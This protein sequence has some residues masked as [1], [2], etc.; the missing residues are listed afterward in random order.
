MKQG[1]IFD[2]SHYMIEDGPGIRT[3][4]FVK[5]CP[6]RCLWCSNAYG[7]ECGTE[8]GVREGKCTGCGRCLEVCGSG[9]LYRQ[10]DSGR[11]VTDFK[12]CSRCLSCVDS[13]PSGARIR[14][15]NIVTVEDV[16]REVEKDR[17]FYRRGNGGVTVSGGEILMQPEFVIALLKRCRDAYLNTAIETSAFGKW[18]DLKEMIL[19]SDT[20][21]IDCKCMNDE[22]HQQ[23]T[24]A[25]NR[26]ILENI[27]K[28]AQ[29]CAQ[30]EI[31]L[32]VRLPLIP[33][34]NDSAE[35]LKATACFVKKL[36]GAP[37]LNV[38]P[39]HNYGTDKYESIGLQYRLGDV[40]TYTRQELETTEALLLQT[41]VNF[42]IGGYQAVE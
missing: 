25:S 12:K 36:P 21:F 11:I 27:Q 31:L 29:L 8:L 38:L 16:L 9:A 5:G 3:N 17:I 4:V 33:G 24:G 26:L 18:K 13:C 15:G 14:V 30:R 28:A 41:G 37:Q 35:N 22:N 42:T 23:L 40:R 20:V 34:M 39:Y 19:L 6:L 32:I 2:I 1:V 10:K 7:L